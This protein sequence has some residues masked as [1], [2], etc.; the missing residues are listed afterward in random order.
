MAP[1]ERAV[2]VVSIGTVLALSNRPSNPTESNTETVPN[3][4]A[5][6]A[7]TESSV[8]GRLSVPL[9]SLPAGCLPC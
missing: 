2:R 8:I 6:L 5:V 1:A 3:G 9:A 4:T 7:A